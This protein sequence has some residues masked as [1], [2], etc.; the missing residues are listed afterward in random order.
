M[1][2]RTGTTEVRRSRRL[3]VSF[4]A[5]VG[6]YEYGFYWYFYQDGT[7]QLEVKL[8]GIISNG[9]GR[10]RARRRP[11]A[12]WSPPGVRSDP[13]ALLQRPPGHD[14]RRAR[15]TRCTRSTRWPTPPAP[16]TRTT[17]PSAPRP[18]LLGSEALAQR[19]VDPL[20]ASLLEDRQPVGAEPPRG[21][22]RLQADARR[23]R[24]ALRRAGGERHPA[25]RLHDQ[26]SVGDPL[27]SR[28]AVRGR[29][30]PE[31]APGRRRAARAT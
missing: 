12:S 25:R 15:R 7:I 23:E 10:R 13:P 3:V 17:M 6:N 14:R 18:T 22:G 31:S 8:T 21:A 20:A 24:P 9:A 16:T 1:D 30:L 11:G 2:W 19:I 29:R 27:R 5:T 26:A 28:G 4:I